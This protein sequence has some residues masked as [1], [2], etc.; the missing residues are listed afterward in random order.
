M[1]EGEGRFLLCKTEGEKKILAMGK[2]DFFSELDGACLSDTVKLCPLSHRNRLVLNKYL[3]Y[4][5]PAAF[6]RKT[7]T[8]G[9]GDRLGLATPG[10]IRCF[11]SS[12]AKPV[13]AQQSKRELDLTGRS[14]EQ[15][16]DDV[17]FA[18]FREG[19]RGGFGADGDHLKKAED[20]KDAL[21]CGYTMITLDCSER[22]GKG[23][24]RLGVPELAEVYL[25]LTADYRARIEHSY[26]SKGFLIAGEEYSFS[27]EELM[28]CALIYRGAVDFVEEVWS[29]Y[30]KNLAR[31]VDLELSIDETESV[32]AAKGHLFVAMELAYHGIEVTSLAPRFI[33]EF[34]KGIDYIGDLGA[35]EAQLKQHAAIARHFGYK[36]SIHSGSDKFSVYPLIG[37]YTEGLLHIKTSGTNWLEAIGAIAVK[38]PALYRRLHHK[39]LE[40]FNEAKIHYHVSGDP[41]KV[42]EPERKPD[43]ALI[44]Y[45][46]DDNSRQLLHITYGYILEDAGLKREIYQT[47][48]EC[49][50]LYFER[51]ISHIG[52]HL[53]LAGV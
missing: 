29:A 26:L 52:R 50:E 42:E 7:A 35:F 27:E 21:D 53:R 30:L 31:E 46:K 8:F 3:P 32:T 41:D 13:L 25:T 47:L 22:M 40:H 16:L 6:G 15:V 19:Y 28:R 23:I 51:L 20:I 18:V 45:L 24:D 36:L 43:E 12:A 4:T 38:N 39:A 34:Q 10:H 14:F 49:E 33:G 17:C 11:R 44:E 37:K 1:E 9:T 5:R 2:G 48:E